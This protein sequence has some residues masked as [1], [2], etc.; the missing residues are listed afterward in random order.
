MIF[1]V[2]KH[3]LTKRLSP[4]HRTIERC[5][6]SRPYQ[7]SLKAN[8]PAFFSPSTPCQLSTK[9]TRYSGRQKTKFEET[10]EIRTR[11]RY[12]R[13]VLNILKEARGT[14]RLS[15]EEQR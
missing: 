13:D 14:K 7:P 5:P 15:T 11:L 12:S 6:S 1:I 9:I 3:R 2:Q 4:I 8:I 10:E